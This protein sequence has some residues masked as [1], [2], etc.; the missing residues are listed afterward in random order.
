VLAGNLLAI[1][2]RYAFDLYSDIK[3]HAYVASTNSWAYCGELG[4]PVQQSYITVSVLSPVEIIV[5]TGNTAY[6][7]TPM[8][9]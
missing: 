5:I 2:K 8:Y 9:F 4:L 3:I 6:K 1:G 7:G